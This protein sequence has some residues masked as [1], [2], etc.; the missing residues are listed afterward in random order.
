[1]MLD[2][3]LKFPAVTA[4]IGSQNTDKMSPGKW[5][6]FLSFENNVLCFDDLERNSIQSAVLGFINT[7]FV[8]TLGIKT[9]II[10][11]ESEIEKAADYSK[12]K[13]K[14]IFRTIQFK[15]GTVPLAE[16]FERFKKHSKFYTFLNSHEAFINKRL[17]AFGIENL[18]TVIFICDVLKSVFQTGVFGDDPEQV[19]SIIL[20]TI[21]VSN[22]FK[23]GRLFS[24]DYGD[25]KK[26]NLLTS[27]EYES[28]LIGRVVNRQGQKTAQ[29]PDTSY[30][31]SI[32]DNYRLNEEPHFYFFG[33]VYNYILSGDLDIALLKKEV[34]RSN[35]Y[36]KA[37]QRSEQPATKALRTLQNAYWA[38]NDQVV[39]EAKDI[40]VETISEGRYPFFEYG[41]YYDMLIGLKANGLIVDD[42]QSIKKV[43]MEG[44]RKAIQEIGLNDLDILVLVERRLYMG[45]DEDLNKLILNAIQDLKIKRD[46]RLIDRFFED[47]V[48]DWNA[49]LSRFSTFDSFD[50]LTP[51]EVLDRLEGLNLDGYRKFTA[52]LEGLLNIK[53]LNSFFKNHL[54]EWDELKA[55][56]I[57]KHDKEES[58]LKR[59]VLKASE[60]TLDKFVAQITPVT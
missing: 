57:E 52:Y 28:I 39:Q 35:A 49:F 36:I 17:L 30:E 56:I 60:E 20:L 34:G 24:V 21:L 19:E 7:H 33:S 15:T 25:F 41:I 16:I 55:L 9:L 47:I 40:V 58:P 37:K 38:K 23:C 2:A 48:G 51:V 59:L 10:G 18:R 54:P 27:K 13:E 11:N 4:L 3:A 46:K 6:Q 5:Q 45:K 53:N 22:E 50:Y 14:L 44:C 12:I 26:L 31:L 8:E 1:M 29:K 43:V 32:Y 42:E